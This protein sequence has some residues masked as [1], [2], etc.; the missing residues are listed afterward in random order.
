MVNAART[1]TDLAWHALPVGAVASL[2]VTDLEL[3]LTDAEVATRRAVLRGESTLSKRTWRSVQGRTLEIMGALLLIGLAAMVL[4]QAWVEFTALLALVV[5]AA[6]CGRATARS[7]RRT[8]AIRR[9]AKT[10]AAYVLRNG[11]LA[12]LPASELVPGDIIVVT[13]GDIVP[14]DGRLF[15]AQSLS[16]EESWW[17]ENPEPIAKSTGSITSNTPLN[18]RENMIFMGAQVASGNGRAIV[19][20]AGTDATINKRV[21]PAI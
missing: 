15:T 21:K 11:R 7:D 16:C 19:V 17:T 14:A 1:E 18:L 20:A 10:C 4:L 9:R 12:R 8:R 2:Q 3:G 6:S 13:A 5:L